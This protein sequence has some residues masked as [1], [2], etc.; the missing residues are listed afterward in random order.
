MGTP[1]SATDGMTRTERRKRRTRAALL[2]SA[3]ELLAEHGP[4]ISVTSITERADVAAGSFYNYFADKQDILREAAREAFREFESWMIALTK[5]ISDPVRRFAARL[6]IF[7]R[8]VDSH[9]DIARVV[10]QGTAGR[11]ISDTGYSEAALPDAVAV[12]EVT[13]VRTP[14]EVPLVLTMLV[15]A[16]HGFLVARLHGEFEPDDA[17]ML[18]E[19]GLTM[20]GV[21]PEEARAVCREPL[22]V[23]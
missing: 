4:G 13:G 11:L 17:D 7:G 9:P 12:A 21:P 5:S 18:A 22:P 19:Y 20:L 8:M 1:P 23:G 14:D 3:R 10:V 15:G 6:R 16:G 2:D